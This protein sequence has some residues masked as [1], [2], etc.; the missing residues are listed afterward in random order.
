MLHFSTPELEKTC[1][2]YGGVATPT[3]DACCD[4]TC[5]EFCGAWNCDRGPG[6]S[7]KCCGS[8]IPK[9]QICGVDGQ[10]APCHL[11]KTRDK[12]MVESSLL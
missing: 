4:S 6:G 11:G 8:V 12:H 2:D 5:G 10:M 9:D 3:A 1:Y 7:G